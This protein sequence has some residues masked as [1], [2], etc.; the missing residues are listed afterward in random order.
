MSA[1][2]PVAH[3]RFRGGV[4]VRP[5]R[6][7]T[8]DRVVDTAGLSFASSYDDASVV[9]ADSP[10]ATWRLFCVANLNAGGHG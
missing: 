5:F 10:F 6:R 7:G 2:S 9:S 8:Y 4:E 3:I 1:D